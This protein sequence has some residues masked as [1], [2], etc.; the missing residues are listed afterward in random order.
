MRLVQIQKSFNGVPALQ[1]LSFELG[2]GEVLAV[3]GPSGCGKTT[4]LRL[5]AGLELP[6]SGEIYLAGRQ[7]SG[8]GWASPPYERDIGFA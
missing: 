7:V 6:D 4:L 1:P 8:P 2:P 3:L 5:V